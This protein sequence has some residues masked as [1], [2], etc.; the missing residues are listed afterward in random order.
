MGATSMGIISYAQKFEDVMLWSALGKIENDF[1]IDVEANAPVFA[2][3]T[4]FFYDNGWKGINVEPIEEWAEQLK[5]QRAKDIS[6]K[7]AAGVEPGDITLFPPR[8]GLDHIR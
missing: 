6:L 8:Y 7:V 5:A 1:Y 4:K 2:S 3:V